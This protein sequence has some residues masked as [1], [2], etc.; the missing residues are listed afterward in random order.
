MLN[1]FK[2]IK[3]H[4]DEIA[5]LE[6][7][8]EKAIEWEKELIKGGFSGGPDLAAKAA[9]D[10]TEVRKEIV[11]IRRKKREEQ[12]KIRNYTTGVSLT[13]IGIGGGLILFLI[14][15]PNNEML[16]NWLWQAVN[17]NQLK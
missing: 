2:R 17:G 16:L 5:R 12:A 6:N 7:E 4:E 13:V 11:E 8:E 14:K 10:A 15:L 9:K 3:E 1:P